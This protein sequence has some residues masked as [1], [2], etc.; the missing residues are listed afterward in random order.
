MATYKKQMQKIVAD[1]R[2]A[3][4]PWPASTS[5]MAQWAISSGRWHMPA[6]AARRRCAEDIAAAMREEYITDRKGRRVRLLHPATMKL[7]SGQLVL[8]DDLR[9]APRSHMQVSFQQ[10]RQGIVGDCRQFKTDVDSYNDANPAEEPVQIVFDFTMD[11]AEL[12][13]ADDVA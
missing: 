8:W 13:A 11:L 4:Q 1:Y 5:S 2:L 6:D 3:G 7:S 10:R 12:E 9:T